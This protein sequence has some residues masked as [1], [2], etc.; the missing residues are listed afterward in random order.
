MFGPIVDKLA[1]D[2][3][4]RLKVVRVDIDQNPGLARNF[5]IRAIPTALL[6]KKGK[7]EGLGWIGVGR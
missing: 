3:R 1:E 4:G 7:V 2:Y 5:G 6:F